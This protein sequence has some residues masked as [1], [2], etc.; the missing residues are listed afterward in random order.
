MLGSS[1]CRIDQKIRGRDP[2]AKRFAA[3]QAAGKNQRHAIGIDNIGL[4][5]GF[6][7]IGISMVFGD[8]AAICRRNKPRQT[9]IPRARSSHIG[10]HDGAQFF[11]AGSGYLQAANCQCWQYHL[12]P[13]ET[14][15]RHFTPIG[16]SLLPISTA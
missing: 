12:F 16:Q 8:D 3:K 1:D 11:T 15:G 13:Q 9:Q 10:Q 14:F 6:S 2:L 7:Q 4:I 5:N